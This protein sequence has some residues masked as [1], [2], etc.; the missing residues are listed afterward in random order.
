MDDFQIDLINDIAVIKVNILTATQRDAKPL[1]EEME[2][3]LIFNQKK[4]II[5]LSFCNNV[6]STF[7]GMIVKIF[8]KVQEK[9]G[10]MKMVYP[11]VKNTEVFIVTRLPKIIDFY[12]TLEE[13]LI[14]FK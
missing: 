11:E 9:D 7:I 6:D 14:S 2:S 4:I 5:D 1:W 13:A 3:K 10:K 12:N 8:R